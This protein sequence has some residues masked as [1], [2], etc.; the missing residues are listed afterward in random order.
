MTLQQKREKLFQELA[1]ISMLAELIKIYYANS[2]QDTLF[3]NPKIQS[4]ADKIK[5]FAESIQKKELGDAVRIIPEH[6]D[7][8]ENEHAVQ[9]WRIMN[10]FAFRPTKVLEEFADG[11]EVME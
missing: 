5:S 8:M 3:R 9:L 6:A 4:K 1:S 10:Y 7:M 11:L 2:I